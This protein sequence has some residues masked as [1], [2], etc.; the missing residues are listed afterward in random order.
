MPVN[1]EALRKELEAQI[2]GGMKMD[3]HITCP[4]GKEQLEPEKTWK[5]AKGIEY[6]TFKKHHHRG[7]ECPYSG[8]AAPLEKPPPPPSNQ[9]SDPAPFPWFGAYPFVI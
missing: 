7:K 6:G 4:E 3:K 2:F 8:H 5:G 9:N 1:Q